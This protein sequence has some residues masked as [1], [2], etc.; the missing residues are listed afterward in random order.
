MNEFEN[1]RIDIL[2]RIQR[3]YTVKLGRPIDLP[4]AEEI[5]ENLL[6]FAQALY[7]DGNP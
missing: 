4:E 7:G 3:H 6:N 2:K 5:A 1:R